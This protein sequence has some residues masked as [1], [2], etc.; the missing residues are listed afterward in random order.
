MHKKRPAL[1]PILDNQAV[2]GAYMNSAWPN[3]P[4]RADSVYGIQQVKEAL[5]WISTDLTR[6]ENVET[7]EAL[8]ELEPRRS[9]IELF[10]MVWWVHFRRVEPVARGGS[11]I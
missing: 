7:S 2:F 3:Q 11:P 10:D 9:R 1:I 6:Q 5:D 8:G 4:A